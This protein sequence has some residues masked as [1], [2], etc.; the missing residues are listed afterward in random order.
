M[1]T[2]IL[3][4]R[5]YHNDIKGQYCIGELLWNGQSVIYDGKKINTLEDFDRGLIRHG[6]TSYKIKGATAIPS[7]SF[8]ID[9]NTYSLRFGAQPFY[10]KLCHGG[11]VPRIMDVDGFSGVLIHCGNTK[12]DTSGC[13]LVG[14][15]TIKGRLTN[16]RKCFTYLYNLL[17]A[18]RNEKIIL[19]IIRSYSV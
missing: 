4:L 6:D 7:G 11:L 18:H 17:W 10:N 5:R 19:S 16:S 1:K 2:N 14:H 9:M 15:N 12:D 3:T 8:H 13:V